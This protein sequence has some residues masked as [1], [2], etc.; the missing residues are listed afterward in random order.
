MNKAIVLAV[1]FLFAAAAFAQQYKWVDPD[2]K[3]RYGD[4]PPPGVKA[5]PLKPPPR[6][7]APSTSAATRDGSKG[8]SPDAAFRKRQE[9]AD[10]DREKQAKSDQD[11]QLKRENCE[12]AQQALRTLESGQRISRT[13]SKGE[14]YFLDETQM[15]QET[16]KARQTVKEWCS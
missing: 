14:R 2:G 12:R 13:D 8:L 16:T 3:V 11:A 9:E 1:S 7:A 15:A 10:Q 4:T 6:G 5:T